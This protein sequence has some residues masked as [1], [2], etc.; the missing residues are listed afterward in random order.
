[1]EII[2]LKDVDKVGDKHTIIKVKN[3]FGRNYLIPR[4]LALIANV[5]NRKRLAE[6]KRQDAN[7]EEKM[8]GTYQEI[9]EKLK[10]VTLK[11]G[12]KAGTSG[13][14]FG[15]VTNIQLSQ[16]LKDQFDV[17]IDRRKIILPEEVKIIGTYTAVLQ[18]HPEVTPNLTFEVVEE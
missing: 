4:G 10:G 9:A 13:K 16:A 14:I 6:L 1:M 17:D 15:S 2:L 11:I 3:G 7:K 5:T 18:L 12:A 8:V